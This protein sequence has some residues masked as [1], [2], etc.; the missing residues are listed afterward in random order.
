MVSLKT[1]HV[2]LISV[3]ILLTGWY[4][5]YEI[6]TPTNPG[7]ISTTLSVLSFIFCALL[8]F[9]AFSIIKKFKTI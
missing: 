4:G 7:S 6:S 1:L 3:S 5:Y 8:I 2:F 9:Y